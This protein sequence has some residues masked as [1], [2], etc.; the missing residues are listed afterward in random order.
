MS[1]QL[2]DLPGCF[3]ADE[4]CIITGVSADSRAVRPGFLF[5]ALPGVN[6]DGRKFIPDAIVSGAA[7]ILTGLDPLETDPGVPVIHDRNPHRRYA[8]MV[9]AF[10]GKQ[11]ETMVAVTGTNGK[12]SVADFARQIWKALG[13]SAASMGTIGVISDAL[14]VEGS[15]T[16]PDPASL[17]K[18][19][20]GLASAGVT[21]CAMEVSSHGLAQH[22]ADGVQFRAAGFT[23][24]TRDH[25][26]YHG[27]DL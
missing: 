8:E 20:A 21:H 25:L 15:L 23:N 1:R 10:H 26:D 13:V 7:V 27:T 6:V 14:E 5:A 19:L 12:S 3:P 22:R 2:S 18:N 17:H 16:T 11:P 24:L 9:A 4:E